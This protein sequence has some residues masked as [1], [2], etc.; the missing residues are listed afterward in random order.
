MK[1]NLLPPTG[2]VPDTD[3]LANSGLGGWYAKTELTFCTVTARNQTRLYAFSGVPC[4][5]DWWRS[6]VPIATGTVSQMNDAIDTL[7]GCAGA[8]RAFNHYYETEN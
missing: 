5:A 7:V 6:R 4:R 3:R 2:E 8:S 1:L